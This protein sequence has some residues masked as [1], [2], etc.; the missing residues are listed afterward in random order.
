[1]D[2]K[3][4]K[5]FIERVK[6]VE[7]LLGSGEKAP[8]LSEMANRWDM[9]RSL[10]TRFPVKKGELLTIDKIA[11]KRPGTGIAASKIDDALGRRST[12]DIEPETMLSWEMIE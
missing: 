6:G 4:F 1:M 11:F 8:A 3:E 5:M 2:P 10:F 7:S 9:K 12:C